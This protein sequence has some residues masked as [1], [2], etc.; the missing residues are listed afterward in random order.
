MTDD[1][2]YGRKVVRL[3]AEAV[4]ALEAHLDERFQRAVELVVSC[5]G[6][7]IATGMGKSGIIAQKISATLASSGTP[8][9][10][11]HP[12]EAA[13]G[14]LGRVGPDDVVLALSNSGESDEIRRLIP[15]V[16]RIGARLIA[17][18]RDPDS[19]LAQHADCVL[20]VGAAPEACPVG[21]APTTSTTAQLALGDALAMTVA[22]RRNFTREEYALYH[23]GGALGRELMKVADLMRDRKAAPPARVGASTRDALIEAGG[24]GRR[25]GALPVVGS[26]GTLRGLL[27]DGDV[28][29]QVLSDPDF[30]DRPIEE[31]MT[32]NPVSIRDDQLAAEAWRA[33]NE[34][35]FNQLPVVDA[36]GRYLGLIDVQD[37]LQAGFTEAP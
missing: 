19:P 1:I 33:M 8:S 7:V 15:G 11:L 4:A 25:P 26:G 16:K 34:R 21:L 9:F 23:P 13:H 24:R 22:K 3:E 31:V 37:F 35:K 2:E 6:Q 36:H 30:I 14:D 18:T 29:R 17:I 20:T 32:K 27:T 12:A 10:F 28:R 5:A